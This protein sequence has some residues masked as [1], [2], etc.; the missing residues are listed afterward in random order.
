MSCNETA[1]NDIVELSRHE[2]ASDISEATADE[3][4]FTESDEYFDYSLFTT[5]PDISLHNSTN[6]TRNEYCKALLNLFRD[7]KV[8]KTHCDRFIRLISSGLPT[9]NNMPKSIKDLLNEMQG[10]S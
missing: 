8:C 3:Q 4:S 2:T 6:I 7:A 5:E 10:K 9:P 1:S